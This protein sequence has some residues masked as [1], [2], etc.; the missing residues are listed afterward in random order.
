M[1]FLFRFMFPK[2]KVDTYLSD[3]AKND[4]FRKGYSLISQKDSYLFYGL[5]TNI[6]YMEDNDKTFACLVFLPVVSENLEFQTDTVVNSFVFLSQA[7]TTALMALGET[8][9]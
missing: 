9:V 2:K 1:F 8:G 4:I 5:R 3:L 6:C 7:I